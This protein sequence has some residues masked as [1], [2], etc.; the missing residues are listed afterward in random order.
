MYQNGYYISQLGL[1]LVFVLASF[2]QMTCKYAK[3]DGSK[4]IKAKFRR[5]TSHEPNRM[6]MR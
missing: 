2:C 3:Q 6:L 4:L 5:R 1:V